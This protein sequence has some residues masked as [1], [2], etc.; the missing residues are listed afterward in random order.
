MEN[1]VNFDNVIKVNCYEIS[2]S[3]QLINTLTLIKTREDLL[4]Q[5]QDGD[6]EQ[7]N[8]TKKK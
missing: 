1:V 8:K 2:K 5:R 6:A 3:D 7:H 4:E